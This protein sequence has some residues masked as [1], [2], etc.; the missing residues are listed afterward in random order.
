MNG[1]GR[2]VDRE[3]SPETR[4]SLVAKLARDRP[5]YIASRPARTQRDGHLPSLGDPVDGRGAPEYTRYKK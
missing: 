3:F 2:S 1:P 5:R 4:Q